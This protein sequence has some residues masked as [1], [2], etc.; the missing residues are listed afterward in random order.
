MIRCLTRCSRN[1]SKTDSFLYLSKT[2]GSFHKID[3]QNSLLSLPVSGIFDIRIRTNS[4]H[5]LEYRRGSFLCSIDT[6]RDN[7]PFLSIQIAPVR[8]H[9]HLRIKSIFPDFLCLF[10]SLCLRLCRTTPDAV[11]R[12]DGALRTVRLLNLL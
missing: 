10:L 7:I 12:R 4:L 1:E 3:L 5:I 8:S 9:K 11:K 6:S 2:I